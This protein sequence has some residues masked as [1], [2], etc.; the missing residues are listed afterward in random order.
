MTLRRYGGNRDVFLGLMPIQPLKKGGYWRLGFFENTT[1]KSCL[2]TV[3][4][5]VSQ[6][7]ETHKM[8]RST[9]SKYGLP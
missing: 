6:S 3:A 7:F 4:L 8:V 9:E 2:K 1:L 5:R